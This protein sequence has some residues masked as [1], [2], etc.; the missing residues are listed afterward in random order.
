M[1]STLD[2]LLNT[3]SI[4]YDDFLKHN[5]KSTKHVLSFFNFSIDKMFRHLYEYLEHLDDNLS[6]YCEFGADKCKITNFQGFCDDLDIDITE[7]LTRIIRE[8]YNI[9]QD[10]H[11][12]LSSPSSFYQKINRNEY[13][14]FYNRN[15]SFMFTCTSPI[16]MEG[17]LAYFGCTGEQKYVLKAFEIIYKNGNIDLCYGAR[18][19]A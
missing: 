9:F 2:L 6:E 14:H 1:Q 8:Y 15:K 13:Y 12:I 16:F 11:E 3:F 19:Y 4:S 5:E 17:E 7:N 18:D 10:K